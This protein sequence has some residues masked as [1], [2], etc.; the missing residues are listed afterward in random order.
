MCGRY[1][2]TVSAAVLAEVFGVSEDPAHLPRYNIAPTQLVP[3][4]LGLE[5]GGRAL[6]RGRWGLVPSWAKDPSIGSRLINARAETVA[7]RPAFRSAVRQRRG[8]LPADGFYEWVPTGEGKRPHLIRY[9]DR[10]VF[11]FAALWERWRAP[12]GSELVS[13]TI[14]TTAPND[15]VAPLHDRMPVILEPA[16]WDEWLARDP[17][18]RSRLAEL[19]ATCRVDGLEV[20]PV[21]PRV[22]RPAND[23]PGCLAPWVANQR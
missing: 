22:N 19:T 6:V 7:D 13:C 20:L 11:A 17:L 18:G 5:A 1:T 9:T 3:L 2:L 4:V 15:L 21:S 8:L 10:R 12:D 16:T 14:L 23:D